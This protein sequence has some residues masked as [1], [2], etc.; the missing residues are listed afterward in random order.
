MTFIVK[1]N[2]ICKF[3][4]SIITNNSLSILC[5]VRESDQSIM[6]AARKLSANKIL[7]LTDGEATLKID[8]SPFELSKGSLIFCF[9][10]E[11]IVFENCDKAVYM[12]IDFEGARADELMRRF[13]VTPLSRSTDGLDGMIPL[14]QEGLARAREHTIDLVAESI[15]LHSF[16]RLCET[17]TA[18]RGIIGSIAEITDECFNDPE[19]SISVIAQR[20]SYN[21][22]YL[23]HYFKEKTGMSYSEYLRSVRLNYAVSLFNNGIDSV[24]NVAILSGFSDPLYFSNVFKKHIGMSP[25]AYVEKMN[26]SK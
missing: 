6:C 1:N 11:S 10:G 18:N 15:L 25:K 14:W 12:Y 13:D 5:F 17:E 2:N 19:L 3:P 8:G 22:K 20:L 23:S 26:I 16:S 21:P 9:A 7:L 4:D 24:K